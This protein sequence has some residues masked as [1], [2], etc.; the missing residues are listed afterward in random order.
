MSS[1]CIDRSIDWENH[2]SNVSCYTP[3]DYLMVID[4]TPLALIKAPLEHRMGECLP[5]TS[6]RTDALGLFICG[7]CRLLANNRTLSDNSGILAQLEQI[8]LD[9]DGTFVVR[10]L[11]RIWFDMSGSPAAWGFLI[12][13]YLFHPGFLAACRRP[14]MLFAL[15][16]V[17]IS[18]EWFA[19]LCT[20]CSS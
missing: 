7:S 16:S 12:S 8:H 11:H 5:A 10:S 3:E 1:S 4:L 2:R 6:S 15:V 14:T 13:V 9:A 20:I 17:E 19:R 18:C